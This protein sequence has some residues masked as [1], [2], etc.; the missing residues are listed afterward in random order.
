MATT[1]AAPKPITRKAVPD[2]N[3]FT[4][5]LLICPTCSQLVLPRISRMANGAI[6]DITFY[7]TNEEYGCAWKNVDVKTRAPG[8][9]E[10][11]KREVRSGND[12]KGHSLFID[13][14]DLAVGMSFELE[15]LKPQIPSPV[16]IQQKIM[17]SLMAGVGAQGASNAFNPTDEI[18]DEMAKAKELAPPKP[19][20]FK[21]P[22]GK[23]A[24]PAVDPTVGQQSK[25]RTEGEGGGDGA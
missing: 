8:M 1:L 21:A 12:G 9:T 25:Y 6:T 7:H 2:Q 22:P 18:L 19:L 16:E 14:H 5:V 15:G 17:S 23:E 13:E 10:G 4:T 24:A 20:E 11:L 3:P